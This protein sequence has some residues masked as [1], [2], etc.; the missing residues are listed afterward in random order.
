MRFSLATSFLLAALASQATG[1]LAAPN[2]VNKASGHH[3]GSN[4]HLT[5]DG[6]AQRLAADGTTLGES[7]IS[8][9]ELEKFKALTGQSQRRDDNFLAKR[10]CLIAHPCSNDAECWN[11]GCV[12]CIGLLNLLPLEDGL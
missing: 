10:A 8:A 12:S 5:E 3:D 4:F 7:K 11:N 6:M 9:G 1:V 2:S